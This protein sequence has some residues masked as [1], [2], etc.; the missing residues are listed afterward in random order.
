MHRLSSLGTIFKATSIE[1]VYLF[2]FHKASAALVS[3][4]LIL[5]ALNP[6]QS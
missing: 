4:F 5:Q 1:S 6:N 2:Y 3:S